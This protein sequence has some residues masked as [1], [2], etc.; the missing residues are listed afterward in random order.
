VSPPVT[1]TAADRAVVD[2]LASII[3]DA[4]FMADLTAR[5]L[6]RLLGILPP[7]KKRGGEPIAFPPEFLLELGAVLRLAVWER[8]GLRDR[9]DPALPPAEQALVDLLAR[10]GLAPGRTRAA[11][12]GT[13][14]AMQV[15]QAA[16]RRLAHDGRGELDV[17]IVLEAPDDG[18]LLEA[19][20]DFL[21][22]HRRAGLAGD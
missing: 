7:T 12:G 8:A 13:G 21:W 11:G 17:D 2:F 1:L 22:A 9:L 16:L 6:D 5:Y 20:A 3:R 10:F 4:Q 15:F 19:L 14:L 18:V